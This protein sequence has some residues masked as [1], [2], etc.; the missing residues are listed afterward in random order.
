MRESYHK[1]RELCLSSTSENSKDWYSLLDQTHWFDLISRIIQGATRIT[2]LLL[3]TKCSVLIHCSDGWDRTS[4]L[5]SLT[6]LMLDSHY[7][8]FNGFETLICKDWL[9]FVPFLL[10]YSFIH[11]FY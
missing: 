9:L 6:Q 5:S 4:Q 1:L 2:R 10:F 11:K 3:D 7:R 8:S